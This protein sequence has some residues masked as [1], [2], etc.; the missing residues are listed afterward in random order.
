MK[1]I[2]IIMYAVIVTLLITLLLPRFREVGPGGKRLLRVSVI[3]GAVVLIVVVVFI[4]V[5]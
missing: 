1:P 2:F 5:R 3:V 4:L